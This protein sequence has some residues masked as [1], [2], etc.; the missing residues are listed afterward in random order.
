[1]MDEMHVL[2]GQRLANWSQTPETKLPGADEATRLIERVGMATLFPASLEIPNLYHAYV[3]DP[4]AKPDSA[5]DSPAGEVYSWR[6]ALGRREA[7]FYTAI[8]RSRPTWVSWDLLPAVLRLRADL[9]A[10]EEIHGAGELS[11]GAL[12][13]AQALE[14]AGGVLSTGD[15]RRAAGFPTGKAERAAYLKAIEE[16]DTRLLLAKVF[17]DDDEDMRHA[18]VSVRYADHVAHAEELGRDGALEQFLTI[19]LLN[20]V[21]ATPALLA[22]HLKLAEPELHASLERLATQG[23]A[24]RTAL[25]GYKGDCYVWSGRAS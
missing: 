9:R 21:Y 13:I 3:G 14:E 6:W 19:Y 7:A 4:N 22:K 16:L 17:S 1:M 12:R 11:D 15:V 18:L 24:T 5:W 20:A 2:R 23:R 8:V 10:P 25:P